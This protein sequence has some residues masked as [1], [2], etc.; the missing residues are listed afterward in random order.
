MGT[1]PHKTEIAATEVRIEVETNSAT[2]APL[3]DAQRTAA[4]RV[5]LL[6]VYPRNR[7]VFARRFALLQ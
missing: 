3:T 2:G 7:P 1:A 6:R 5:G 4:Q